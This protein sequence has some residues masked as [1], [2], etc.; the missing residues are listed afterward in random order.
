MTNMW[1]EYEKERRGLEYIQTDQGFITYKVLDDECFIEDLFI[2]P[3]CR[4]KGHAT[5]LANLVK[6]KAKLAEC[7]YLSSNIDLKAIGA[8]ESLALQLD[9][10]MKPVA[11][12]NNMLTMV[13]EI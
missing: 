2:L 4:R 10:G 5:I 12:H 9:Y 1:L 13:K 8:M 11:A 3:N 7:K 6:E